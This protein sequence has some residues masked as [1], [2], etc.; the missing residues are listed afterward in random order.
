MR[1]PRFAFLLVLL[2]LGAIA[3]SFAVPWLARAARSG[4]AAPAASSLRMDP[5]MPMSD[6][7]MLRQLNVYYAA[8]PPHAAVTTTPPVDS[9]LVSNFIFNEDGNPLTQI[10]TAH[11]IA[12]QSIRF[13]WV[14]G[15]HTCTSGS[16]PLDPNSGF[17]FDMPMSSAGSNFDFEFDTPG[18]YPFYCQFHV[19][20]NNMKGVVEVSAAT[21]TR[22][23]TWGGIKK[24]YR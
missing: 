8:H 10:D 23:Q 3:T 22:A 17:F 14:N 15:V 16:G 18:T 2:V 5:G 4:G 19:S 13:K 20:S 24:T 21:P 11:I 12:G 9:F 7:E 6:A 1:V